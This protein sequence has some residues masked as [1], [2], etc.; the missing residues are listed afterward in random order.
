MPLPSDSTLPFLMCGCVDSVQAAR[1]LALYFSDRQCTLA[2]LILSKA[3]VDD[4][5]VF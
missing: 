1:E 5:E 3:D 2:K 4:F